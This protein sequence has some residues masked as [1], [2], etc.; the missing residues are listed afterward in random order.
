MVERFVTSFIA[1]AVCVALVMVGLAPEARA[2]EISSSDLQGGSDPTLVTSDGF[3]LVVAGDLDADQ[4]ANNAINSSQFAATFALNAMNSGSL[5]FSDDNGLLITSDR[6]LTAAA[7]DLQINA[8]RVGNITGDQ[9]ADG[10]IRLADLD[11]AERI[12]SRHFADG[13]I[14]ALAVQPNSFL[15]RKVANEAIESEDIAGAQIGNRALSNSTFSFETIDGGDR[16]QVVSGDIDN[17]ALVD[18]SSLTSDDFTGNTTSQ[19]QLEAIFGVGNFDST[20]IAAGS[21]ND[22]YLSVTDDDQVSSAKL[23]T[24]GFSA[25]SISL[26]AVEGRH[27]ADGSLSSAQIENASVGQRALAQ[28]VRVGGDQLDAESVTSRSIADGAVSSR[29]VSAVGADQFADSAVWAADFASDAEIVGAKIAAASIGSTQIRDGTVQGVDISRTEVEKINEEDFEVDAVGTQHIAMNG[30]ASADIGDAQV[31]SLDIATDGVSEG[32]FLTDTLVA[33]DFAADSV[34]GDEIADRAIGASHLEARAVF[35]A[36]E[37]A[38]GA[39]RDQELQ[40]G[41]VLLADLSDEARDVLVGHA[42]GGV[43]GSASAVVQS[44]IEAGEI[45]NGAFGTT[46]L[47][48][49]QIDSLTSALDA[50]GSGSFGGS[51]ADYGL[52]DA[53]ILNLLRSVLSSGALAYQELGRRTDDGADAGSSTFEAASARAKLTGLYQVTGRLDD[54]T[55]SRSG[56]LVQ[57]SNFLRGKVA[58]LAITDEQIE[59]GISMAGALQDTYVERDRRGSFSLSGASF[60]GR[61][62]LAIG[63]GVRA[64]QDWQFSGAVAAD[65]DFDELTTRFKVNRQW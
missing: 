2:I 56:T 1:S 28:S 25:A 3:T 33:V 20:N 15:A 63:F 9:I 64:G 6:L 37:L 39:I 19:T 36:R 54:Q 40:D 5:I 13:A 50:Y 65:T 29:V 46:M 11:G 10:S 7:T 35:G 59:R 60:G 16:L 26:G 44:W 41:S 57:R 18:V 32:D 53:G 43:V 61:Q 27:I 4:I 58:Q 8:A 14:N 12:N 52:S 34:R 47:T 62:G 38:T 51:G 17:A 23:A 22:R 42:Y 48:A 21:I 24:G 55:Q 49:S 31:A 30:I 45:D